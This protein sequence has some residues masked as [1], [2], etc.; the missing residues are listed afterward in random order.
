MLGTRFGSVTA[1]GEDLASMKLRFVSAA[2]LEDR[3]R[4]LAD[5]DHFRRGLDAV[6]LSRADSMYERAFDVLT[7]SKLVEALDIEKEDPALRERY[8]KGSPKHQGDG[9]PLW[10][11]QLLAGRRRHA[12]RAGD[13]LDR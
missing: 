12:G 5:M 13:W 9:A 7:T 3:K 8:G 2:R 6:D 10:N 4:L 11:D 1:D